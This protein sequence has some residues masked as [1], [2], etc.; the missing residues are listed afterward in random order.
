M[1]ITH[2]VIEGTDLAEY[3]DNAA[4]IADGLSVGTLYHTAGIVKVV[5]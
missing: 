5:T 1:K 4:A 2:Q 3:A